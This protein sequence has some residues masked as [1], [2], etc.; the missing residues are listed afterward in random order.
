MLSEMGETIDFE[1]KIIPRNYKSAVEEWLVKIEEQMKISLRSK[2]EEA[3]ID[4]G[5]YKGSRS[6]WLRKWPGQAILACSQISWTML[7]EDRLKL[8]KQMKDLK[9]ELTLQLEE[10]VKM[11]RGDLSAIE[12]TTLNALITLEVHNLDIVTELIA[13]R[14]N[15]TQDFDWLSQ[16][17]YYI[18]ADKPMTVEMVMTKIDYGFE[19]LGN[20]PRL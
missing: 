2:V 13:Q 18:H 9:D 14:C 19:Y 1:T 7:V 17:R 4:L 12:R 16:L 8:I 11:I 6:T 5:Q 10:I 20:T 15:N 3:L